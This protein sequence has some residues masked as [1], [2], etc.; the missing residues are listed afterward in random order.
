MAYNIEQKANESL[1]A[2][3]RRLSKT[4][5]QRLVRIEALRH[6]KG[7][8]NVDKW[9]YAK[10]LK[11]IEKFNA[12]GK[13]FNT[14]PPD[15][16]SALKEK[17]SYIKEFLSKP[18]SQK[19]GIVKM[20]KKRAEATNKTLGADFTWQ[21]YARIYETNA[22][23]VL[24][25]KGYGSDTIMQVVKTLNKDLDKDTIKAIKDSR[26]VDIKTSNEMIDSTIE[27]L[28]KDENIN[29]SELIVK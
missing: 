27:S 6:T 16:E 1:T 19:S 17:I 9:A 2:Y 23:D 21:D 5:D 29:L 8:E 12:G 20:Y 13:R 4:A 14:A 18:T 3:Y 11:N 15:S 26:N 7:F 28:L 10:A 24:K 22:L 25:Q